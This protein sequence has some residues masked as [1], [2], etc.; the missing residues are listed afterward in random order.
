MLCVILEETL[1]ATARKLFNTLV[2]RCIPS[3]N[4]DAVPRFDARDLPNDLHVA[5]DRVATTVLR[6]TAPTRAHP[7]A[8]HRRVT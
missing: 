6:R 1:D 7:V 3:I 8:R 2:Y 4:S 5:R